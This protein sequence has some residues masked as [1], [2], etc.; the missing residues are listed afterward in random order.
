MATKKVHHRSLAGFIGTN[1][2]LPSL[3][4]NTDLPTISGT[5]TVG[6]TLTGDEGTWTGRATPSLSYQWLRDGEPIGEA[7]GL[8]YDLVAEDEAAEISFAVTGK[9]WSGSVVAISAATTGVVGA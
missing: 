3:P 5:A 8:T 6:E 1:G 9:N 2:G 7:T 4:E